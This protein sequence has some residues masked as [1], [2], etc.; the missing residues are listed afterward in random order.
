MPSLTLLPRTCQV[1]SLESHQW[2]SHV[3]GAAGHPSE[4]DPIFDPFG[5]PFLSMPPPHPG[6]PGPTAYL[7]GLLLCGLSIRIQSGCHS[8]LVA[9]ASMASAV[10]NPTNRGS[11]TSP[12]GFLLAC[13]IMRSL[14]WLHLQDI[15]NHSHLVWAQ[16]SLTPIGRNSCL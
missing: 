10:A 6:V 9:H 13:S 12:P 5:I 16:W 14:V 4:M 3:L 15:S 11:T 7:T 8:R 1:D 2:D